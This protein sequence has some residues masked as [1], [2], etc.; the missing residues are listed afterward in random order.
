MA[1]IKKALDTKA[2][3]N[4]LRDRG[5]RITG[6]RI[7]VHEAMCEL[8]HAS[9]DQVY[10]YVIKH[11]TT[12]VTLASVYN[13]LSQMA[14]MGVYRLRLSQDNKLYFDVDMSSNGHLYDTHNHEFRDINDEHL[15]EDIAAFL[16]NK[17]FRGYKI[18][19]VDVQI[20]CHPTRKKKQLN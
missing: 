20:L 17:R 11:S 19:D 12:P 9:A 18:D 15:R 7:A 2:L 16:R 3:S 6:Q 1:K 5:M 10:E 4:L 14:R 13:T 8:V